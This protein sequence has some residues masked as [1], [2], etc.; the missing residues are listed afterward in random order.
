MFR[1]G[2]FKKLTHSSDHLIDWTRTGELLT[3]D[4]HK[5]SKEEIMI[6]GSIVLATAFSALLGYY[7][8]KNKNSRTKMTAS[9]AYGLCA[10]I[11][12]HG[13]AIIPVVHKRYELR[14]EC[15]NLKKQIRHKANELAI[16]SESIEKLL[17]FISEVNLENGY[18]A[19]ASQT[20]GHRK[21]LL[22][23]LYSR[24]EEGNLEI[25]ESLKKIDGRRIS[26]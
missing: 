3:S 15:E 21:V 11:I 14:E 25:V 19:N 17:G 9:V 24:L 18:R 12:T 22:Q 26:F 6:R 13:I 23:N 2:I 8:H 16:L 10:F 1:L 5:Y 20:W 7:A 4:K